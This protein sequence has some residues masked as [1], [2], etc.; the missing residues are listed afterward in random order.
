M[1]S[2]YYKEVLTP[3]PDGTR[4]D[5]VMT[6]I[7]FFRELAREQLL[8]EFPELGMAVDERQRKLE[9]AKGIRF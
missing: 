5:E 1:D 4:Y 8:V 7:T 3:G 6:E 2:A 9:K